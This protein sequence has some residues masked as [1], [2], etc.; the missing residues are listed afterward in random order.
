MQTATPQKHHAALST[1]VEHNAKRSFDAVRSLCCKLPT[2]PL[3]HVTKLPRAIHR[4]FLQRYVRLHLKLST[5][6]V[7]SWRRDRGS[8]ASR[9]RLR[10]FPCRRQLRQVCRESVGCDYDALF[11]QDAHQHLQRIAIFTQ[12]LQFRV[13]SSYNLPH[14]ER[15]R[16]R[17]RFCPFLS[18]VRA[19]PLHLLCGEHLHFTPPSFHAYSPSPSSPTACTHTIIDITPVLYYTGD[20]N[21]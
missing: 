1:N 8:L 3:Q 5:P 18:Q 9:S 15:C 19:K 10:F 11:F 14:H 12:P 2:P 16:L 20:R 13:Y 7:N 21:A 4:P 17:R 6:Y